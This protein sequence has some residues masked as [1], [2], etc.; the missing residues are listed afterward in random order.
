MT[1]IEWLWVCAGVGAV[2]LLGG[3]RCTPKCKIG[4]DGEAK[5]IR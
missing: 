2:I 3:R 1:W 5:P 4:L